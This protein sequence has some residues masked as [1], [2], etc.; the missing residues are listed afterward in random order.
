MVK[1]II[2]KHG[3]DPNIISI[4]QSI[5]DKYGYIPEKQTARIAR[6][7]SIPLAKIWAVA[8]FYS[9]FRLQKQGKYVIK[10]C[11]GTACHVNKSE[12][13]LDFLKEKLEVEINQTTK[14]NLFTLETVNCIGACARAPAVMINDTVYGKLDTKKL[15]NIIKTLK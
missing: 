15:D 8:T 6:S 5:Q 2:K 14:D 4:L 13:L 9:Q 11:D 1:S 7:L 12:E 10:V 3:D